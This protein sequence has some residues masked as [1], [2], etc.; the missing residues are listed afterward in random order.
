M[1]AMLKKQE[2]LV[3]LCNR[4]SAI[5]GRDRLE[6]ALQS[7]LQGLDLK[8]AM[9]RGGWHRLGGVVDGNYAPVSPNLTKWV[10]E[11][12]GGDLDELFFNYR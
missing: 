1:I 6:E 9:T 8:W 10:D 4:L 11:T 7:T 12:A 2:H 3:E 5:D